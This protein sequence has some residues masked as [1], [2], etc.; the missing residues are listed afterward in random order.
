VRSRLVSA[1]WVLPV[2]REPLRDGAVLVDD[3]RIIALGSR[4]ELEAIAR[5]DAERRHFDGAT[6]MPGLVNAHTHLSLTDLAGAIPRMPFAEW[7]HR[8]VDKMRSWE[9]GD[10]AA[11][12][13][14]GTQQLLDCGVTAVGD[15][16]YGPAEINIA[17]GNGLAGVFYTEVLGVSADGLDDALERAYFPANPSA[18]GAARVVLGISPH[19]PYTSGPDL[20]TAVYARAEALGIPFAIHAAESPAESELIALGTGPLAPSARRAAHGFV[21][22]GGTAVD[23]LAEL[24]ILGDATLVHLGEAST[25]DIERMADDNVRGVVTCPRSNHYLGN[26]IADVPAL[27]RRDIPVGIGTDSAAS[28]DDLDLMADVRVLAAEH[29][30]LSAQTLI[31]IVTRMGARAIGLQGRSGTLEPG[32]LGDLAIFDVAEDEPERG[33]LEHAGASSLLA[34][35]VGGVWRR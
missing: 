33:I 28:N 17:A 19:S 15:I 7:L 2:S 8:V 1:T 4:A 18:L 10:F 3:G 5:P 21:P 13:E 25:A 14:H 34:L 22:T 24:G 29:P 32:A 16:V 9:L 30:S 23:Y 31:D 20:L 26:R 35:L 12:A 6:I 11:S 27:L